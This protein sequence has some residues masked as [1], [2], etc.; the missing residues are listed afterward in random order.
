M[1]FNFSKIFRLAIVLSIFFGLI[2]II[3]KTNSKDFT[4]IQIENLS[5][6]NITAYLTLNDNGA[7]W[8]SDVNGIFGIKSDEKLQGGVIL[9]PKQI[10]SYTSDKPIAGNISFNQLPLNCPYPAP[11]LFE[12]T[13]NNYGTI[14][15][16][17][18]TTDISCVY[19][20]TSI[21]KIT[22]SGGGIWNSG[23]NDTIRKI[24]NGSIY[25]NTGLKGVYP[26]GCTTCTGRDGMVDCN[27]KKRYEKVNK[28]AICNIQRDASES[29][30]NVKISYIR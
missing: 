23:Q 19:G 17:Q 25:K 3:S 4:T 13:L 5:D 1:I 30:G 7:S 18:E 29:G 11:T 28:K 24:Q 12:F 15:K 10:L 16:A 21:G 6:D 20:V 9:I 26:Y 27:N 8:V 22:Y 2:F 14:T